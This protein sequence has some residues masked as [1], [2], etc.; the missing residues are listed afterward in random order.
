LQ[1]RTVNLAPHAR[2]RLKLV[3]PS[4]K[5]ELRTSPDKLPIALFKINNYLVMANDSNRIAESATIKAELPVSSMWFVLAGATLLGGVAFLCVDRARQRK[6][7]GD[8][9][10]RRDAPSEAAP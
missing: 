1:V 6:T 10:G 8:V 7:S 5:F 3:P 9:V 2:L 4:V